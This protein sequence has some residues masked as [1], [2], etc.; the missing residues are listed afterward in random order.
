MYTG[1]N[2]QTPTV[3][4]TPRTDNA[5]R[6]KVKDMEAKVGRLLLYNQALFELLE[7][8]GTVTRAAIEAK[9]KEVDLRDGVE[10]G[11]VTEIPL[12]CPTCDRVS[13]S[14]NWRCMYCGLEFERPLVG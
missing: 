12:R 13:S 7:A 2:V 3:H 5:L 11:A 9:M 10:D 6:G 14:K 8:S 1:S 4:Q